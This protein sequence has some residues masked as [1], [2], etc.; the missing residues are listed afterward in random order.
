[1]HFG[2]APLKTRRSHNVRF[3]VVVLLLYPNLTKRPGPELL[4]LL[5]RVFTA[6]LW[7]APHTVHQSNYTKYNIRS[8]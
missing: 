8:H 7:R 6:Q 1:M 2:T 4:L 3:F 5:A